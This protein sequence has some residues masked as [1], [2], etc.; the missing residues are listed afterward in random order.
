MR[1][2]APELREHLI[3][4]MLENTNPEAVAKLARYK[5][6]GDT[7]RFALQRGKELM[8]AKAPLPPVR[9]RLIGGG[10]SER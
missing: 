8:R 7:L 10:G 5:K 9:E 6:A 4:R 3:A 2:I 1:I